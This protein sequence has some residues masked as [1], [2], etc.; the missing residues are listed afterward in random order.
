[1][2]DF[3]R[4]Y[5]KVRGIVLR[6]RKDYYLYGW[7]ISDWEQEGMLVL[8]R[9]LLEHPEFVRDDTDLYRYYKT[10][11][12]N[13]IVDLVRKQSSEKRKFHQPHYE[14][15]S[16]IGHKLKDKGM[17]L[18]DLVLFRVALKE[19][20]QRLTPVQKEQYELLLRG[21]SFK[22]RKRLL[23]ELREEFKDYNFSY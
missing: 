20:K 10:K 3:N 12:R 17:S 5:E 16:E 8:Y 14:E 19:Y 13:H 23:K 9:L 6:C 1:M 4:I 15:I 22:G 18:D 2:I 11:F 21:R 7:E